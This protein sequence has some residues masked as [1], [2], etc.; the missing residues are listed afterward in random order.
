MLRGN[1]AASFVQLLIDWLAEQGAAAIEW[2][3]MDHAPSGELSRIDVNDWRAMLGAVSR[4]FEKPH[5]GLLVGSRLGLQEAG[6]LGYMATC[7]S[8]MAE[9]CLRLSQF[10]HLVY[11][12]NPLNIVTRPECIRLEWG[13]ENGRPG[14]LVD[15]CAIAGLVSFCRSLGG[16]DVTPDFVSFVN[17]PPL[18]LR[19]YEQFFAC[20]V[21]F[22]AE[23]TVVRYPLSAMAASIATANAA[24]Q[25]ALDHKARSLLVRLPSD[26]EPVQGLYRATQDAIAAGT[27]TLESV[28][29]RLLTSGRTLQR[30]LSAA[31]TRFQAELDKVRLALAQQHL[32]EGSATVQEIA[33]MLAYNDHS[34]FVHAFR[35][36]TG[37]SPT[38]W[39]LH[40]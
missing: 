19:P 38:A 12:V 35:R 20:D 22:D 5:L 26:G 37:M 28:A 30:S 3:G 31:G 4:A 14:P 29:V 40:G 25:Q 21:Q 9:A 34:A 6:L 15:E 13:T 32:K 23:K 33:W 17:P 39:R 16:A 7:C 18:D 10:E 1:I 24:L 36:M 11:N 27:P 8:T 2:T